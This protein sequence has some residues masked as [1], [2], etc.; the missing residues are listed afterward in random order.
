MALTK[1]KYLFIDRD[2]T[3]I[4]EPK[5]NFQTDSFEKLKFE[6][7]VISALKNIVTKTDYRLVIVTN[8]DGL[9]TSSLP[10]EAFDGP[11]NLMLS[12]F[13]SEGIHFDEVLID[14]SFPEDKSPSRKPEIGLVKHYMND[15]L[16]KE[17][18]YVIGDRLTDI[19]LASNMG[20]NGVYYGGYSK[21]QCLPCSLCSTDWAEIE[22]FIIEGSRKVCCQRK[23]NET[24]ISLELDLNGSG[25]AYLNT[26]IGF[27]DHMLEQIARHGLVDLTIQVVGDLEV[28]EHHTIEDTGLLLGEAFAIALGTKKGLERYGFALPMDE[29]DAQVLLDF[30]GRPFLKWE[31][32]LKKEYVGDFP[33][34]MTKHFFE[35][36][37][38]TA[39]CN[40]N[41][42]A[43]GENTHHVIE[44]LF[45]A[46]SRCVKQAIIQKG[47]VLPSSKG[48][49]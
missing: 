32:D 39:K 33:T 13:E 16:D 5:D 3:L 24:C 29:A 46:F 30:G 10:Q 21:E 8:Q 12:I 17:N 14:D 26:G 9:G 31:V 40:L 22:T 25:K 48:I 45:K 38:Q 41:I 27:F 18:S 19:Q 11:H 44:A 49:L 42:T 47:S 1:R 36:F 2:G 6:K 28:D 7:G 15:L 43:K 37:C 20:I 34:D 4:E 35:S 23:T